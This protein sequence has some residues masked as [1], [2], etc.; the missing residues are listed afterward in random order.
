MKHTLTDLEGVYANAVAAG[1]KA[2]GL[3][4]A[5]IHVPNA[6]SCAGVFTQHKFSA[7]SV[8]YTKRCIKHNILKAIVINSG[9]ANAVTGKQGQLDTKTIAKNVASKLNIHSSQVGVAST[10]IIG[11]KLPMKKVE[12][13]L[14]ELLSKQNPK[15]AEAVSRAILTTDLVSKTTFIEKKVGKK[16]ISIAGITKGSGMIAP[17]MATTLGFLVTNAS[18]PQDVLQ[19]CLNAAVK[20]SY[21]MVSVDT[22]TSTNDMLLCFATGQYKINSTDKLSLDSFQDALNIAAIDLAK[23]IV[24]DGEGATK[25]IQV[26][27]VNAVSVQ[28]AQKMAK[29]VID[30]PLVKTAIHGEDPNWGRI[31]MAIGKDTSI[32]LNPEKVSIKIGDFTIFSKGSPVNFDRTDLKKELAKSTIFIIIDCAIGNANATAWGCDLTKGY[33]D[34]NT[35]YN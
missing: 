3:D 35:D 32:K 15:N 29:L 20:V 17:N 9:N 19:R 28:M 13:G 7:S 25:L 1:I 14:T 33:I 34:I 5:Y 27:V 21:N 23:Q 30:S 18:L 6:V 22:D 11:K 24:K 12:Q 16:T 10:G 4:L 8:S 31:V 26:D 2:D